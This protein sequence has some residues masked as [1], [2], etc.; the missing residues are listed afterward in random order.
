MGKLEEMRHY[1]L[2]PSFEL[3]PDVFSSRD[4][5]LAGTQH[6][7][8]RGAEAARNATNFIFTETFKRFRERDDIQIAST[9]MDLTVHR[10]VA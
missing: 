8:D 10:K 3:K 1:F 7:L 9:T 2:I 6:V 5:Q 4:G